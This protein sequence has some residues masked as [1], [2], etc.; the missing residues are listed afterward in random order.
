M[1][2]CKVLL[3]DDADDLRSYFR[4]M[5]ALSGCDVREAADGLEALKIIETDAPDV[6]VLDLVL[7]NISGFA[8]LDELNAHADL[9]DIPVIVI[10]GLQEPLGHLSAAAVL[11]K[12]IQAELLIEQVQSV[13]RLTT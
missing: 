7:P 11:R 3:V 10:T 12:P 2:G 9:R 1:A 5:L 13:A 6:I 4:A 8:V